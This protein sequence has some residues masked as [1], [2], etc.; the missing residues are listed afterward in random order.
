MNDENM[1]RYSYKHVN[2]LLKKFI[3]RCVVVHVTFILSC[4]ITTFLQSHE[5]GAMHYLTC[6]NT[7]TIY[8]GRQ[9]KKK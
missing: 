6:A 4:V 5:L 1:G 9:D 2:E 7:R 8:F 3:N